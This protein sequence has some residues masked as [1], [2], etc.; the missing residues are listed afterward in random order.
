MIGHVISDYV[1]LV[2]VRSCNG[3]LF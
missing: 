3:R 2:K 1:M